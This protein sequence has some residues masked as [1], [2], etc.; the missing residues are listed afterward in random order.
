MGKVLHTLTCTALLLIC[1]QLSA[2]QVTLSGRVK[3]V[4]SENK[5]SLHAP[6]E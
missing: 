4:S 3:L 2:Q 1:I 5:L 6:W